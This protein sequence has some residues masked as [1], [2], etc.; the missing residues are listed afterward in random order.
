MPSSWKNK[1][2][3]KWNLIDHHTAGIFHTQISLESVCLT[4]SM[5]TVPDHTGSVGWTIHKSLILTVST[6]QSDEELSSEAAGSHREQPGVAAGVAH[7]ELCHPT[8]LCSKV[9]QLYCYAVSI[10]FA[11]HPDMCTGL[12]LPA[13][14]S[15]HQR[16]WFWVKTVS[17]STAGASL[18]S[19]PTTPTPRTRWPRWQCT[20][21]RTW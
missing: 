11:P 21:R 7:L 3:S 20:S 8:H 12:G 4:L 6:L 16:F 18:T 9:L 2:M 10:Q 17:W 1:N 5:G 13:E 14:H 19:S 15:T